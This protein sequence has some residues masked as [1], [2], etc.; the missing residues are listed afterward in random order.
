MRDL[1]DVVGVYALNILHV[2]NKNATRPI[3]SIVVKQVNI[4]IYNILFFVCLMVFNVTF[5]NISAISWRSVL[6]VEEIRGLGEKHRP[7]A[8]L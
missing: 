8:S 6:V 4:F 1:I 3:R 2:H 7:V 5:N